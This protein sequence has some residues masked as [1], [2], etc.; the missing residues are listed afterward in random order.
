MKLETILVPLDGSGLAE[1]ALS[2]GAGLARDA[3]A[4]LILI[5]A[6]EA[7]GLLG[8]DRIDVQAQLVREAEAYLAVAAARARALGASKVMTSV[9]YGAAPWAIG[10]AA[11]VEHASL[12]VMTTH[13]R[14][15]LGRLVLGSVAEALLRSTT[16]PI[17]LLR[18][19]RAPV[20]AKPGGVAAPKEARPCAPESAR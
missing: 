11:R 6:V 19:T 10:E 8:A 15:G 5:R 18:D 12:I 9:W 17:L 16:A 7:A 1:A 20:E 14:S 2:E 13:G 4:R 3:G